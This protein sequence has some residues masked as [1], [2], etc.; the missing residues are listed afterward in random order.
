[1]NVGYAAVVVDNVWG[2]LTRRL[3]CGSYVVEVRNMEVCM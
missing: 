3:L 2:L 1:M